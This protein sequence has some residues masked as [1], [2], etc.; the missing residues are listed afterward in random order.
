MRASRRTVLA[1][2][3]ASLVAPSARGDDAR[4]AAAIEEAARGAVGRLCPGASVAAMLPDGRCIAAAAGYADPEA[5]TPLTHTHRLM[6]GST[7][8]T[9]C[10]ATFL[11][12]AAE[13]AFAL[14]APIA[15]LFA[16]EPW[17]ARLPNAAAL[18]PL[19]L[20]R[21]TG[22]LPQFLDD[23]DFQRRYFFDSVAGRDTGYDPRTMLGFIAGNDP[24]NAPG[25]AHHYSDL[26]Y[27]IL[28][29]AI[30][31]RSGAPYKDALSSRILS[32]LGYRADI[33][34]ADQ[35]AIERLAP[36][37]ARGGLI[38]AL[39]GSAG[40]TID[41][42]GA[43]R[44]NP[45]LE[46]TGGGLALTPRAL[47]EFYWRLFEGQLLPTE[48]TRALTAAPVPVSTNPQAEIGYGLGVFVIEREGFGRYFSHSG[49]YPGYNSYVGYF[50][51]ARVS[52][53]VQINTDHGPDINDLWRSAARRFLD[54]L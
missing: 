6:S 23:P 11:S 27:H 8:K 45:A 9:F 14:D 47:A 30:E 42:S 22:G 34:A 29:L 13:G 15:P 36:G 2:M 7:G 20:L 37:F 53:A 21:H 51:A 32:R 46:Y 4:R 44:K 39:T 3:G 48:M 18:T 43:L 49:Y 52:V 10:A 25:A 41:G 28:G 54:A 33:V 50:P 38:E 40:R 24:L 19:M 12:M 31:K 5:R 26:G 1:S 16:D 35:R 17:F